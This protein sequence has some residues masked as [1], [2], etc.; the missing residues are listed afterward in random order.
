VSEIRLVC[1][2]LWHSTATWT[3]VAALAIPAVAKI[4][5]VSIALRGTSPGSRP[6]IISAL[7]ELFRWWGQ[8]KRRD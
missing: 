1:T 4:V 3:V 5:I 8:P 6:K 2:G 7:A